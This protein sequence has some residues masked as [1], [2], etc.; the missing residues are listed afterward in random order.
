MKNYMD[1]D[2]ALNKYSE[3]IVYRFADSIVEVTLADYLAANPDKTEEDFRILKEIS[4]GIF[5]EQVQ[6]ENAQTAK[7]SPLDE[8]SAAVPDEA[9]T[10]EEQLISKMDAIEVAKKRSNLLAAANRA[11]G[12]LTETQ[13]R[14]YLQ[15][16]V[17][18]MT[19]R[20]IAATEGSH[21]TSVHESLQAAEKKIKKFLANN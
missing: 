11:L 19:V 5:L 3:G 10:P 9:P 16:H 14:R 1:S 4:D 21:F 20:R 2:Y 15:H 18:G 6:A 8:I 13:R 7:N 17:G 12:V